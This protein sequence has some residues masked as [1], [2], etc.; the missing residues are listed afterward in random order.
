MNYQRVILL[1]RMKCD[2][3]QAKTFEGAFNEFFA[4]R[5]MPL[6]EAL[7]IPHGSR[8]EHDADGELKFLVDVE[9]KETSTPLTSPLEQQLAKALR[10]ALIE[11]AQ[12]HELFVGT[13]PAVETLTFEVIYASPWIFKLEASEGGHGN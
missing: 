7:T 13:G 2:D 1:G 6:A 9:I 8:F 3:H 12:S 5:S 10:E 11:L 4:L